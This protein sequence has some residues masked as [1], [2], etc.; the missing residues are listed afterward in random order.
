MRILFAGT[1]LVLILFVAGIFVPVSRTATLVPDA[2][3]ANGTSSARLVWS[4]ENAFGSPVPYYPRATRVEIEPDDSLV[5]LVGDR[6][7]SGG[8]ARLEIF[9]RAGT[10]PGQV[11]VRLHD[12]G[13][14]CSFRLRLLEV[15]GDRDSDGMPDRVELVDRADRE[16]FRSWFVAIAEAQFYRPDNR[17]DP[18][19]HDCAGLIRFAYKEALRRHD[20]EWLSGIKYLHRPVQRDVHR[21]N[22]PEVPTLGER[23]FRS[24]PGSY[25]SGDDPGRD[26]S[27]AAGARVLWEHNTV[28]L[29]KE[30]Q[31]ARPGDLLFFRDPERHSSPMHSM[32]LLDGRLVYHTGD[33][34]TGDDQV[35]MVTI[36]DLNVHRNDCWHVR[37]DNPHF[38]G[39]YR[40][41]IL[42]GGRP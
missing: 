25:R 12:G 7:R 11:S 38:L 15:D 42:E 21:Y 30:L 8:P 24:R 2:I 20:R 9:L 10:R 37:P 5:R 28:F 14:V 4:V 40:W 22:Y 33:G 31:A 27:S 26:F 18:I 6:R 29:G 34:Q 23:V 35:R 36:A 16:A 39:F 32:I 19:H 3:P 13:E 1:A 17:W 41:K